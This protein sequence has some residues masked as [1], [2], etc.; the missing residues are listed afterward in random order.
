MDCII[1][2]NSSVKRFSYAI[3][4]LCRIGKDLYIDFNELDGL[5]LKTLNDAKSAYACFHFQPSFFERCCS[6][7]TFTNG[8]SDSIRR[9]EHRSTGSR[10]RRQTG[11]NA[12]IEV[13][14]EDDTP[15]QQASLTCRV[16]LRTVTSALRPRKNVRSLR[17][18]SYG[19]SEQHPSSANDDD[20]EISATER[21]TTADCKFMQL[22][23]EYILESQQH[24][25]SMMRV[26][27]RVGVA[28]CDSIMAVVSSTIRDQQNSYSEI[29]SS[30][31]LF[32][33]MLDPLRKTAEIVFTVNDDKKQITVA[34]FHAS[35]IV[36]TARTG[37]ASE[38]SLLL[39]P[40]SMLLKTETSM[41][42]DEFECYTWRNGEYFDNIRLQ[43]SVTE[44]SAVREQPPSNV[45]EEVNLVFGIRE[46]KTLVQFCSSVNMQDHDMKI[47]MSFQYGGKPMV[48]ESAGKGFTVQLIM[49]TLDH[50]LLR[51]K[52]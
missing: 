19:N 3:T 47:V 37:S 6:P 38:A 50:K 18:R 26:A 48:F 43:S 36:A 21:D 51:P 16:P 22:S 27:H 7:P 1:S 31:T 32:T 10:K 29:V 23:F 14:D 52:R 15:S 5:Y 11:S 30:P 33:K 25:N 20:G 34:S 17:I 42:C 24:A 41:G 12:R 35:D 39:L 28:E 46:V 45:Q 9:K 40:S 4:C 13:G 2:G 49:A 44:G 8:G